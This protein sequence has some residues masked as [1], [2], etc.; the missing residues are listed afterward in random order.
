M[1]F[2]RNSPLGEAVAGKSSD[3][4]QEFGGPCP[5]PPHWQTAS[6][7][8]SKG[9]ETRG[10]R[11]WPRWVWGARPQVLCGVSGA[12]RRGQQASCEQ[13]LK[14]GHLCLAWRIRGRRRGDSFPGRRQDEL[15]P[16]GK[17]EAC[18]GC[19]EQRECPEQPPGAVGGVRKG[20]QRHRGNSGLGSYGG[21]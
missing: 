2:K 1:V 12:P 19:L 21:L 17:E 10:G 9:E 13:Q 6:T 7:A 16:G 8:H 11:S 18:L 4:V 14:A 20:E 3:L 5:A 15:N